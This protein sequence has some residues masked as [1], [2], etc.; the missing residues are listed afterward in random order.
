M[1]EEQVVRGIHSEPALTTQE[2]GAT[3]ATFKIMK[4]ETG[5]ARRAQG[6]RAACGADL[7]LSLSAQMVNSVY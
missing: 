1:Y 6:F 2:D 5:R 7:Q 3:F 4:G